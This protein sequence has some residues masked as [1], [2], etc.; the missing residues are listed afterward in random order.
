MSI[1]TQVRP[2][3][4]K[5]HAPKP[6]RSKGFNSNIRSIKL[7][8]KTPMS[9]IPIDQC[10]YNNESQ[11]KT[12]LHKPSF[13]IDQ[14]TLDEIEQDFSLFKTKSELCIPN[15]EILDILS[16][17]KALKQSISSFHHYTSDNNDLGIERAKNPI[18]KSIEKQEKK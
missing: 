2:P 7:Y 10:F 8:S 17:P 18:Y 16:T 6:I 12:F 3:F 4:I 13:E 1:E 15:D 9:E 11:L 14:V 5:I